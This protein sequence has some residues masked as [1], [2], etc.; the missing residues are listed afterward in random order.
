MHT[1]AVTMDTKAWIQ[2]AMR[3]PCSQSA[4]IAPRTRISESTT[5]WLRTPHARTRGKSRRFPL[6]AD[7]PVESI[8][9]LDSDQ[10]GQRHG[11]RV[12]R[13]EDHTVDTFKVG[14]VLFALQEVTLE[15]K[16]R[17][18]A[19]VSWGT[20]PLLLHPPPQHTQKQTTVRANVT[21]SWNQ[22]SPKSKSRL[23]KS[24]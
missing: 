10:D 3:E 19:L 8:A 5:R 11:H 14:I 22:G 4:W 1:P 18:S 23:N 2:S 17:A 20:R 12:R 13:L 15:E 24:D 9:H 16:G 6:H 7:S 21:G